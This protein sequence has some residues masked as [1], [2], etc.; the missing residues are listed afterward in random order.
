MLGLCIYWKF[1]IN[2]QLV[3][4]SERPSA[5]CPPLN[6]PPWHFI[7]WTKRTWINTFLRTIGRK[8]KARFA[9]SRWIRRQLCARAAAGRRRRRQLPACNRSLPP[10]H[11]SGGL[12]YSPLP[13]WSWCRRVTLHEEKLSFGV[14]LREPRLCLVWSGQSSII[15]VARK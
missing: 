9:S 6:S 8:R 13:Y 2:N 7:R 14:L 10:L 5:G 12:L 4:N 11:V 15:P 1:L 3:S